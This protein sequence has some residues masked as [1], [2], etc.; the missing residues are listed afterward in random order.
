[1]GVE[2]TDKKIKNALLD[3]N[4]AIKRGETNTAQANIG[5]FSGVTGYF[6]ESLRIDPKILKDV[7]GMNGEHLFRNN[8]AK[9]KD[10]KK[11]IEEDGFKQ[12]ESAIL[13]HVREDGVPFIT[14]GN[15]RLAEALQSGR[16]N[17][18]VDIKYLRGSEKVEG[19]LNPKRLLGEKKDTIQ[20][21][22]NIQKLDIDY[23]YVKPSQEFYD[24]LSVED[25]SKLSDT[26]LENLVVSNGEMFESSPSLD[27]F[28]TNPKAYKV[29]E[30]K[31]KTLFNEFDAR[32]KKYS[33]KYKKIKSIIDENP[34]DIHGQIIDNTLATIYENPSQFGKKI[35]ED[36]LYGNFETN[37]L[38]YQEVFLNNF[39]SMFAD[40]GLAEKGYKYNKGGIIKQMS[41]LGV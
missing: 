14:E 25:M 27:L 32:R 40:L 7:K 11:S 3:K 10:L 33:D 2:Y 1:M 6:D 9:L 39:E 28:E 26:N 4:E 18:L 23:D 15:H 19:L 24:Q 41:D 31:E 21:S 5:N 35:K 37:S 29:A 12:N 17:I 13:V 8:S 38:A 22:E 34:E 16:E 30:I 36:N 20:A